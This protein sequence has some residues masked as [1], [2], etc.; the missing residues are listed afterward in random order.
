MSCHCLL[1][2]KAASNSLLKLRGTGGCFVPRNGKAF[3]LVEVMVGCAVLVL[4]LVMLFSMTSHT[5]SIVRTASARVDA[6]Q[7]ARTAFDTI[8]QRI[9]QA[10]MN[11]YWDYYNSSNQRR[12]PTAT[13]GPTAPANFLPAT[14]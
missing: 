7:A 11:T 13:T 14:Y 8:S 5:T 1:P 6:F 4:L 12:D 10:T 3:T 2:N 9:S